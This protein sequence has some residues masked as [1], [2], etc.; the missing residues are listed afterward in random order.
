MK[1][2]QL[3]RI[4]KNLL[5][6]LSRISRTLSGQIDKKVQFLVLFYRGK[7]NLLS[8]GKMLHFQYRVLKQILFDDDMCPMAVSS[9]LES[10]K[11]VTAMDGDV[12]RRMQRNMESDSMDISFISNSSCKVG[13][14]LRTETPPVGAESLIDETKKM[15][16]VAII[17]M[18]ALPKMAKTLE[19]IL[20]NM[21][22]NNDSN[23]RSKYLTTPTNFKIKV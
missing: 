3:S 1:L 12:A 8:I 22:E 20:Q 11:K 2:Y 13:E 14:F 9:V 15:L 16:E 7:E 5:Y 4:S 21:P 19:P 17:L 23:E 18:K 10:V 6:H